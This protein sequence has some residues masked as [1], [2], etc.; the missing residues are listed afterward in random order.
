MHLARSVYN[1]PDLVEDFF[2]IVI[3][4]VENEVFE[5]GA[6]LGHGPC[7]YAAPGPG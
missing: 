6:I 1:D 7:G 5:A 4:A 3:S 2:N